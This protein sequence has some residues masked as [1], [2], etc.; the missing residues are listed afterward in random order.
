MDEASEANLNTDKKRIL[1]CQPFLPWMCHDGDGEELYE[2]K[3]RVVVVTILLALGCCCFLNE[4]FC[5]Y[6]LLVVY[7]SLVVKISHHILRKG[8][9]ITNRQM[10]A[11]G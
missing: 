11:H 7:S 4:I 2:D 8:K 1:K 5:T 10:F 9:T 6:V 3:V